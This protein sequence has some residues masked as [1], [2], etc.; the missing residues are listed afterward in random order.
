MEVKQL[1][2]LIQNVGFPIVVTVWFMVRNDR[3]QDKILDLLMEMAKK[4]KKHD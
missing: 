2:E 4:G 3:R 1:V